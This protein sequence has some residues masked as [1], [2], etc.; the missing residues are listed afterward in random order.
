LERGRDLG[1]CVAVLK[2]LETMADVR[3]QC[4]HEEPAPAAGFAPLKRKQLSVSEIYEISEQLIGFAEHGTASYYDARRR[5]TE[6]WC[7]SPNNKLVCE[8]ILQ[9]KQDA[10]K[11]GGR[12][13][14]SYSQSFFA[15][16][17]AWRYQ[18]E[19]DVDNDG[20]ADPVLMLTRD[21]CGG[22]NYKGV[23]ERSPTYA[24][25]MNP[26]YKLIDEGKTRQIFGHPQPQWPKVVESQ[27][28][29]Y[30]GTNL[31]IFEFRGKTYFYTVM[32]SFSDLNGQRV[33]DESLFKTLG[34]FINENGKTKGVC[35]FRSHSATG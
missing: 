33:M 12:W 14:E 7:A 16:S 13:L 30:I 21:R 9:E 26:S 29:R 28:F 23:L 4:N 10:A 32:N 17:V 2:R 8:R 3:W 31:G 18:L 22:E 1:I 34:V 19:V 24:F 35:E 15:G 11:T 25:I 6:A 5:D 27:K 20:A